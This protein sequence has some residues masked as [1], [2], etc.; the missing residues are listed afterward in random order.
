MK[1]SF[2]HQARD[3]DIMSFFCSMMSISGHIKPSPVGAHKFTNI[4]S[5]SSSSLVETRVSIY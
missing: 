5:V 3:Q 2:V 4:K 1:M